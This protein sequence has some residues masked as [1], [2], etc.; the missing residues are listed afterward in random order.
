[1]GPV[2]H[3]TPVILTSHI[4]VSISSVPFLVLGFASSLGTV[5]SPRGVLSAS[6]RTVNTVAAG[7]RTVATLKAGSAG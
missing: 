7:T 2:Q 6:N 1:M 3:D 5:P 4:G